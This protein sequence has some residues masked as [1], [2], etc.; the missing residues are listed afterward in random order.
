MNIIQ[1]RHAEKIVIDQSHYDTP[2]TGQEQNEQ[3]H[4][5]TIEEKIRKKRVK[6]LKAKSIKRLPQEI[7]Q[8]V[9]AYT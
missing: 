7:I 2:K 8:Y 3:A 4:N 5:D 1:D 6:V 9:D